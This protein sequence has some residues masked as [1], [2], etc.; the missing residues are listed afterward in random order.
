MKATDFDMAYTN[1]NKRDAKNY[2]V[3]NESGKVREMTELEYYEVSRLKNTLFNE[4]IVKYIDEEMLYEKEEKE[5]SP[6]F[7]D[8]KFS[9]NKV[10]DINREAK[11]EAFKALFTNVTSEIDNEQKILDPKAEE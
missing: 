5:K 10:S 4:K 1:I 3:D 6:F 2:V 7:I 8:K 11:I 9:K